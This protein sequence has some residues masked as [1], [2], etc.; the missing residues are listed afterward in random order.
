MIYSTRFEHSN[1][2]STVGTNPN[3]G[4]A[5]QQKQIEACQ[6]ISR[7]FLHYRRQDFVKKR[8][9]LSQNIKQTHPLTTHPHCTVPLQ[10]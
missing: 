4:R 7:H 2:S 6:D 3:V 9:K 5:K 10:R 8:L 1:L